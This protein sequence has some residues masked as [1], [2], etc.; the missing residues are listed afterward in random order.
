MRFRPNR[1]IAVAALAVLALGLGVAA[2]PQPGTDIAPSTVRMFPAGDAHAR[3]AV[4]F[5]SGDMGFRFGL[6]AKVAGGISQQLAPTVG[7]S[8]YAMFAKRR[9]PD[10]ARRIVENAMA[11]TL[12]RTGAQ[13]IVLAGESYGADMVAT[14]APQLPPE[15]RAKVAAIALI[16]PGEH[17]YF[18]AD[19]LGFAYMGKPDAQPADAVRA[20]DWAP[21]ICIQGAE[22]TDS[23]CPRL[24]GS[25][26]RASALPGGHYLHH[27]ADAVVRAVVG[28]LR[29]VMP[30]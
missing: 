21:V 11:E 23:L 5:F 28:N 6:S 29:A 9:T 30:V 7:F 12:A 25:A 1:K 20:I 13:K 22:E 19:P 18:R 14:I 3:V 17:V 15:L 8:S 27:D 26:V 16:V 4:M 24:A 2:S 10:E